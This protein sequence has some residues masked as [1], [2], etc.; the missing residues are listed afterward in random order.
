MEILFAQQFTAKV[1]IRMQ[2]DRNKIDWNHPQLEH[3]KEINVSERKY[4]MEICKSCDN[5][6]ALNI[7]KECNCFMPLKTWINASTCPIKKW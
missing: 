7:C 3:R 5:L 4:R 1:E 6:T 2:I